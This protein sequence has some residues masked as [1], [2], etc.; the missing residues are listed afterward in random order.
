MATQTMTCKDCSHVF[1]ETEHKNYYCPKCGS[2][3]IYTQSDELPQDFIDDDD[4]EVH[5]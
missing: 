4:P 5:Q 1:D 3:D 2:G